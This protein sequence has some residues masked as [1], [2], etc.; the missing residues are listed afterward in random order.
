M[1]TWSEN[2]FGNDLA[3]DVRDE[4]RARRA[5]GDNAEQAVRHVRRE[6][7]EPMRDADD[8]RTVWIAMAAAQVETDRVCEDHVREQ[9]M[10][11]IAWCEAPDRDPERF[12]FGLDALAQLRER[13]SDQATSPKKPVK[14]K[15]PPGRGGEVV[16]VTLPTNGDEAVVYIAGPAGGDRGDDCGRVVLLFDL[17]PKDVTADSVRAALVTWRRYR[18]L[19]PNG[20]LGRSVGCY[21]MSGKL[22]ARRTKVLLRDV[23]MPPAFARLMRGPGVV[24]KSADLPWVVEN[25]VDAWKSDKWVVDPATNAGEP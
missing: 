3:A 12:P 2:I 16:L 25:D 13:L 4:Y 22:P 20:R 5:S 23:A 18:Q 21:D 17:C 11:A 9:A 15:A 8:R 7:A 19:W 14:A 1:G 6:F 10:K 24:Y